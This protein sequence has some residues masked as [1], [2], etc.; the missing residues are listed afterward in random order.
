ML[1]AYT[2]N[3]K[4]ENKQIRNKLIQILKQLLKIISPLIANKG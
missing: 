2:N 3:Y 4:N 1:R